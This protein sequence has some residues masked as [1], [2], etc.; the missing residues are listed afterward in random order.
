MRTWFKGWSELIVAVLG[1]LAPFATANAVA[2]ANAIADPALAY[3][4]IEP[5]RIR[6]GDSAIIRVTS[7]DGYL[8]TVPLP[9]VP[10]LKFEILG[11]SQGLELVN[12]KSTPAT[13]ILIRVTPQFLGVFTIPGLT[14]KAGTLG[15]EVVRG[16]EPNPYAFHSQKRFPAPAPVAPAPVPKGLQLKA[17]GAAFVQLIMPTRA[18]YVGESVPIDIEVGIRP[19]IVTSLNGPPALNSSEFTL[20]NLS[21]NPIRHEQVIEGSP[22]LVMTWHTMV[23][24]V[25]PG[26]FT[27]SVETPLSVRIN[28]HSAEDMAFAAKLGWPFSQII[29]NGIPPKE[30]TIPSPPSELKVLPLPTQ[31]QP[32]DFSG[33]VGNFQ[34]SSD[35][36][37][38]VV[39]AGDPQTLRLHIS[40][41]GNFDRVDSTMFDHLEHWKTYP[42]KSSFTPSDA[43]GYRGEKVFEQPLIAALPGEQWIPGLAFS[44]FNPDTRQYERARTQPIK[45]TIA[46][47]LAN[48]PPSALGAAQSLNSPSTGQVLQGLRP[49]HPRARGEVRD[50]RPLYFQVPFLALPAA[51]TVLLAGSW[52]VVRPHPARTTSKVP[53]R[54]LAELEAAARSADPASFFEV[55][56]KSLLQTFASRWHMAPDQIN[57]TEL[58]IRL[59]TASEDIERLFALADEA[60]YS[61]HEPAAADLQRWLPLIQG[62]LRAKGQLGANGQ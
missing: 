47:P 58:R 62:H 18:V 33:A 57:S 42:A 12:G 7:L 9:A 35:V 17:G 48:T 50:L 25:K 11:R 8:K 26:D 30:V 32:K 55:A 21:T 15:L 3:E 54:A 13:Y 36:T 38:S 60:K 1:L 46:T 40:G 43:A 14:P 6:L 45:V 37:P 29:Y 49:D 16:N 61:D 23:A 27:L 20:N 24:A 2:M 59:G 51:L 44:Y 41:T 19:G 53:E 22:F 10:G 4:T 34:I 28:S 52:F 39:A 56:R 31:G 5:A